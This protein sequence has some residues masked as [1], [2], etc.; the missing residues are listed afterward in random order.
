MLAKGIERCVQ[1][2]T[3]EAYDAYVA[4]ALDGLNP[5]SE[6][7]PQAQPLLRGQLA[8]TRSST[9][10]AA[11]GVPSFLLDHGAAAR[12]TSSST[13]AG[14]CLEVWGRAAWADYNE[15]LSNELPDIAA[16]LWPSCLT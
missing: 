12:R 13:G 1:I 11:S 3:P 7:A 2:W 4:A 16:R 15:A 14:D 10:R 8:S 9:R 5:L 6:P